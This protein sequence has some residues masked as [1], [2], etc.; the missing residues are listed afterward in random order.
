MAEST[1]VKKLGIKPGHKVLIL[2][3]PQGY[4]KSLDA[5]P[6]GTTIA[7]GKTPPGG[8]FDLVQ[9]FAHDKAEVDQNARAVTQAV[10]PGGMLW[11]SYPKKTGKIKTDLSRDVGWNSVAKAGWIGVSLISIDDTWSSMRYRPASEVKSTRKS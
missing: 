1:I 5:L 6:E 3:A 2:N 8:Q 11:F 9:Y 10:K 4:V 7:E